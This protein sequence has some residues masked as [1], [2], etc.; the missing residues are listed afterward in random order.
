M[1]CRWVLLMEISSVNFIHLLDLLEPGAI[2]KNATY[3][4]KARYNMHGIA[5]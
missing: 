4:N 5:F 2:A 3:S 1:D